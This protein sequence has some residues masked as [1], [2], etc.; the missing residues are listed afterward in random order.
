MNTKRLRKAAALLAA[1]IL[2]GGLLFFANALVGNP[3]SRLLAAQSA[4]SYLAEQYPQTDYQLDKPFYSFKDGYYY[5]DVT[6]P[7]SQDSCFTLRYGWRGNLL[8]D[9]YEDL[10]LSGENT[11]RRLEGEYFTCCKA[12]FNSPD[13]PYPVTIGYGSLAQVYD[14]RELELPQEDLPG[15]PT[16]PMKIWE[17]ELDGEYD[18]SALGR[19]HGELTLY[20][21]SEERTAA[22]AAEILLE[23]RRRMEAAGLPF[24]SIDF[25]LE[26]PRNADDTP[27]QGESLTI[28]NFP[29]SDIVEEGLEAR[30]EAAVRET[31]DYYA[32]EDARRAAEMPPQDN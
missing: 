19:D 14:P 23:T 9:N 5:V 28:L 17:L 21:P 32:R 24:A 18:L 20:V 31:Q 2:L 13:F 16:T 11:A 6:S 3:L 30:I 12:V 29:C 4:K 25:T 26:P 15:S 8:S 7:S 22:K 1:L 27:G 10:V